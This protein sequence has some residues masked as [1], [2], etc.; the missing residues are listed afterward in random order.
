MAEVIHDAD[1]D[2]TTIQSTEARQGRWGR[3]VFWVLLVS[4]ILAALVLFASW[5]MR[6]GDL[7]ATESKEAHRTAPQAETVQPPAQTGPTTT[8]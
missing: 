2:H 8:P 3:H 1:G 4:T 7:A 6:S 5:G